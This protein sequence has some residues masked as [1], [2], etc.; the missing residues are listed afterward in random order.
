M[1]KIIQFPNLKGAHGYISRKDISE[2]EKQVSK[3]EHYSKRIGRS[4]GFLF[5]IAVGNITNLLIQY[6]ILS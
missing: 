3:L 1:S 6:F 4:E 5:G 2:I